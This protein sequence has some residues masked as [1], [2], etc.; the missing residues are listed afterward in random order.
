MTTTAAP[1]PAQA[2]FRQAMSRLGAAVNII[3]T[4]GPMGRHGITASAVCSVTDTPPTLLVCINRAS[5]AHDRVLGNGAFCVNVLAHD[6]ADLALRFGRPGLSPEERFA[7]G[8]WTPLVTGAPAL[9][10]AAVALDC[11]VSTVT[12]AGTHSVIL[13]EVQ[14]LR[15]G[16][17]GPAGLV[18]FNRD[19]HR[20]GVIPPSGPSA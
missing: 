16:E 13:G 11:R 4:D 18:Y 1:V 5:S 14:A 12:R 9:L 2:E 7:E 17:D 15:L 10:G 20:L 19:F 3:T 6:H 8:S